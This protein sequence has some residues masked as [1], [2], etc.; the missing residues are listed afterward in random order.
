[1]SGPCGAVIEQRVD[2]E[3]AR[4]DLR[5]AGRRRIAAAAERERVA[6]ARFQLVRP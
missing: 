5:R 4:A 6:H 1:M 3:E 2:R